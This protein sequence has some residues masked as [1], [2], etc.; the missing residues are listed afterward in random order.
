MCVYAIA[1]CRGTSILKGKKRQS[2]F[3]TDKSYRN[4]IVSSGENLTQ[5]G[6]GSKRQMGWSWPGD[7]LEQHILDI[8]D[9]PPQGDEIKEPVCLSELV[10][11][12]F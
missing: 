12:G 1:H 6:A 3:L 11:V 8:V 10:L 2:C 4:G 9:L 7:G 5:A